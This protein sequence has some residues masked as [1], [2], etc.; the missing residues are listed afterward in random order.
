MVVG[1]GIVIGAGEF[2]SGSM[3]AGDEGDGMSVGVVVGLAMSVLPKPPSFREVW[4]R[5][6]RTWKAGVAAHSNIS[7]AI[8]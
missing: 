8:L 1:I 3:M 5:D 4:L 6:R 2:L 7:W